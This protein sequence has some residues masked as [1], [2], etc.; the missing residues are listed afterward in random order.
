MPNFQ[1]L[2][3]KYTLF[4]F[5]RTLEKLQN[6]LIIFPKL[7]KNETFFAVQLSPI[8]IR[9]CIVH[10]MCIGRAVGWGSIGVSI[11]PFRVGLTRVTKS[12]LGPKLKQSN[13]ENQGW[14]SFSKMK[15]S[16]NYEGCPKSKALCA[17][18][19]KYGLESGFLDQQRVI[20][21]VTKRI[22]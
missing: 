4:C 3:K 8:R 21:T 9:I 22:W 15:K 7:L 5:R 12:F 13:S 10:K 14:F 6:F 11:F 17:C 2:F 19:G 20:R 18:L 1:L 16:K